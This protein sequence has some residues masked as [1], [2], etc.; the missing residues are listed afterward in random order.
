MSRFATVFEDPE[1]EDYAEDDV[2]DWAYIDV[3]KNQYP[4]ATVQEDYSPY[5]TVNS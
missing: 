5:V 4:A 3:S 1:Y 2:G